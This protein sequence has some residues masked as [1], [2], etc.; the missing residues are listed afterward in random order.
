MNEYLVLACDALLHM[1]SVLLMGFLV[2]LI[3]K[4]CSRGQVDF[5]LFGGIFVILMSIIIKVS[6]EQQIDGLLGGLAPNLLLG[7]ISL[8]VFVTAVIMVYWQYSVPILGSLLSSIF[9]VLMLFGCSYGTPKLSLHLMPEGQRFAEFAG[10]ASAQTNELMERAKHFK[11]KASDESL[12]ERALAALSFFTSEDERENLSRD[13]ASGMEL[14]RERKEYMDNMSEEE[15]AEYRA[16]MSD[17]LQE[18]GLEENRYDLNNIK[19]ATPEDMANLATFMQELSGEFDIETEVGDEDVI[20][21]SAVSLSQISSNLHNAEM[22]DQERAIFERIMKLVNN[23]ELAQGIENARADILELKKSLPEG[24][25]LIDRAKAIHLPIPKLVFNSKPAE[26]IDIID[27]KGTKIVDDSETVV[28]EVEKKI[29]YEFDRSQY[30]AVKHGL[31]VLHISKD[32]VDYTEWKSAA[33]A[34]PYRAWFSAEGAETVYKLVLEDIVLSSGE[35]W[36][37]KHNNSVFVFLFDQIDE[38]GV[39]I[40]AIKKQ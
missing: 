4:V 30:T 36:E 16:A 3:V 23:G 7:I 37:F 35:H 18:Q 27:T 33:D 9:I 26:R 39:H 24:S 25:R 2:S 32:L 22:S 19:N 21:P 38:K 10:L 34:I 17:F 29:V 6:L 8:A 12:W 5:K 40:V 11:K 15:L 13:F 20:V 31:W 1:G 14:Y 28:E